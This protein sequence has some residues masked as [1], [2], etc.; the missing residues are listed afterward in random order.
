M[1]SSTKDSGQRQDESEAKG[2]VKRKCGNAKRDPDMRDLGTAEKVGG[3]VQRKVGEIKKFSEIAR[4]QQKLVK[5]NNRACALRWLRRNGVRR[6]RRARWL[7][8]TCR[9]YHREEQQGG[10]E[11]PWRARQVPAALFCR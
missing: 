5:S 8:D 11:I 9:H 7:F 10:A 6:L 4:G 2:K 1:K 3:K